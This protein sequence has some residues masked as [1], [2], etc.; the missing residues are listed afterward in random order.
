MP[1]NRY[2]LSYVHAPHPQNTDLH[3]PV[4]CCGEGAERTCENDTLIVYAA[5]L[6]P[7]LFIVC[8]VDS[9]VDGIKHDA[10]SVDF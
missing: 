10:G 2:T 4:P 9:R 3:S 7:V 8:Y 6:L 1:R 5:H